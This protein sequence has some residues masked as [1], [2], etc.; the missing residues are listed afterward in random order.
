MGIPPSELLAMSI[1]DYQAATYHWQ[2]AQ[3]GESEAPD[4]LSAA[5]FDQMLGA[6]PAEAMN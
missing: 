4:P 3:T 2:L 5:D 6:I 1:H